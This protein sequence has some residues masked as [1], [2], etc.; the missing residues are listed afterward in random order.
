MGVGGLG[1]AS[2]FAGAS[3]HTDV[4]RMAGFGASSAA[5]DVWEDQCHACGTF[6]QD[7][8]LTSATSSDTGSID[9]SA[10]AYASVTL[11]GNARSDDDARGNV[12]Y[13]EYLAARRRWRRW[14][15]KPPRRYRRNTFRP[16]GAAQARLE[17]GPYSR[18]YASFLPSSAFAGG[19]GKGKSH[20]CGKGSGRKRSGTNPR[21]KDGKV[22]RCAKCGSESHL[23]RK[24]PQVVGNAASATVQSANMASASRPEPASLA[25]T[26][27]PSMPALETWGVGLARPQD[28][29]AGVAFHYM[30]GGSSRASSEAGVQVASAS[31]CSAGGALHDEF[32][33]LESASQV[34]RERQ[35]RLTAS[36]QGPPSWEA[37]T[38]ASETAEPEDEERASIMADDEPARSSRQF[39]AFGPGT[40]ASPANRAST[41]CSRIKQE[42]YHRPTFFAAAPVPCWTSCMVGR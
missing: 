25:L 4:A 34:G 11:D 24:C 21:G 15:G 8:D 37:R 3:F 18:T 19:K 28:T 40:S 14:S 32:S 2:A 36:R 1:Q 26:A 27:L 41:G 10:Q 31:A 42:T 33:R 16:R 29:M 20:D 22:L 17:R 9:A 7:D 12:L 6:F 13:Q 38:Q 30:A 23:W 39:Q 5:S 35:R